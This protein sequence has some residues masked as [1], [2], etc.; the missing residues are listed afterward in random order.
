MNT[1]S[2][3]EA[4]TRAVV[5]NSDQKTSSMDPLYK[6]Q[7]FSA[8]LTIAAM[9]GEGV[10]QFSGIYLPTLIVDTATRSC[11][12]RSDEAICDEHATATTSVRRIKSLPEWVQRG[13]KLELEPLLVDMR[14]AAA[15]QQRAAV[16]KSAH[17]KAASAPRG[18]LSF[19][20]KP[21]VFTAPAY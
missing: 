1:M 13:R 3:L 16:L 6:T 18:F 17:Q 12:L 9:R 14:A 2:L 20:R 10:F 7:H 21:N 8:A 11:Y 19:L 15:T 5:V 4:H